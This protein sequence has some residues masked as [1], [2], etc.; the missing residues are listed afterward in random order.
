[1][2]NSTHDAA[3]SR[4]SSLALSPV[5]W[6]TAATV[7]FYA[8]IPYLPVQREL[9]ARYFTSH[10]LEYVTAA[11][12]FLGL[13]ILARKA[14]GFAAENRAL[15]SSPLEGLATAR[16]MH[17]AETASVLEQR[18]R[19]IPGRLAGT[20]LIERVRDVCDFIRGRRSSEGLEDHLRHLANQAADRSHESYGMVR[21]VTWAVPILGFLGTVM[22]ITIAIANVTPEQLE[23]SLNDVTGGLAVAFDTTAL[24]L[25]LS[26]VLVFATFVVQ[27]AENR[28]LTRVEDYAAAR[29]PAVFPPAT[30]PAATLHAA[31]AESARRLLEGT[32]SLIASHAHVWQQSLDALRHRWQETLAGQQTR[33]DEVLREGMAATLADHSRQLATVRGEFLTAFG[34]LVEEFPVRLT[35]AVGGWQSQLAQS[36]AT[37]A[38]GLSD[39]NRQTET[40]RELVGGEHELA[41]LEDRLVQ[42][43][44]ALRAAENFQE[45]V[46]S[47]SA[48]V[49]LLTARVRSRA[50]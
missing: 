8:V 10:P 24:A 45:T 36:T 28:I 12:F 13:A 46:H 30:S 43:L 9:A 23:T 11:L 31:E 6:A 38:E 3:G 20:R 18:L 26:L 50:A 42:N 2:S 16:T 15:E 35:E 19:A 47:L 7:G 14:V 1:M 33:L 29:L 32:E 27:G 5:L 34:R 48:A 37:L 17:A 49:H 4:W 40:L 41:R 44:E 25:A 39:L 22:G 21:T